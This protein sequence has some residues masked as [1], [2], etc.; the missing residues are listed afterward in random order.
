MYT[1]KRLWGRMENVVGSPGWARTNDLRINSPPL[2]QL[3]YRGILNSAQKYSTKPRT[4]EGATNA[5]T[6]KPPGIAVWMA[7]VKRIV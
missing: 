1:K 5:R 7:E 6:Q 4:V 3:S 2:Y